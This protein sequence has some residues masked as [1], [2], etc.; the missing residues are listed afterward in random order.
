MALISFDL[1]GVLQKNPFAA[2]HPQGVFGRLKAALAPYV[3]AVTGT[4]GPQAV[5]V[6]AAVGAGAFN[7]Q[8]PVDAATVA[9]RRIYGE[10]Q[11]RLAAGELVAAYDW[12]EIVNKVGAELGF[13]E[14]VDV[15]K[16]VEEGCEV[17]GLIWSYPGAAACLQGLTDAG[18]TVVS[19]TN[20]YKCYQEPVMRKLGLLQYLRA[21]YSPESTG[22]AKPDPGIYRAAIADWGGPAIHIGDT[23]LQDVAGAARAAGFQAIYICQ[24]QAPDGEELPAHLAALA[25]WERPAQAAEWLGARRA[26]EM[27][28]DH[29][30][31]AA[32]KDCTPDAIVAR[33]DEVQATVDWLLR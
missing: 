21:M 24:I 22:A 14:Q 26:R 15:V 17:P 28:F 30:P 13:P 29:T 6:G 33:L 31:A 4:D 32:L 12:D 20:G 7:S 5:H 3:E 11:A 19:I 16:L 10:H 8:A 23:L 27:K 18:H 1:D 25:P 9:L 2:G